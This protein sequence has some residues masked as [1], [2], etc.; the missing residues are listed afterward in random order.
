MQADAG[1][2]RVQVIWQP[3]ADDGGSAVTGYLVTAPEGVEAEVGAGADSALI[4][5]L[6]NGREI[7]LTV[8]AVND[9]GTSAGAD[10]PAVT[11]HRP[12]VA[13]VAGADRYATAADGSDRFGSG[14]ATAFVV[15]GEGFADALAASAAAGAAG[16]P[17]LLTA[18]EH[19]P[20]ATADA[21]RRLAPRKIVVVG[22]EAAVASSVVASL[23]TLAPVS[24]LAGPDR[25][26]TAAAVSRDRFDPGVTAAYLAVGSDFPDALAGGAA[27][28][29]AGGP[30][31][32][33]GRDTVPEATM[34]ELQRLKPDR[35]EL[36]GGPAVVTDGVLDRLRSDTAAKVRRIAGAD[37][38]ETAVAVS[39][40]AFPPARS[41]V[42]VAIGSNFPDA[43]AGGAMAVSDDA[44]VLLVPSS[45]PLPAA[46]RTEL[47]RLRPN[48]IVA[49]GGTAVLPDAVVRE[50]VEAAG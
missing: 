38:Y 25:F 10:S 16:A 45:G 31:L 7:T 32:L 46:V 29:R 39:A 6:T 41:A 14:V 23:R 11:P 47:A 33:V 30:V 8:R 12:D 37:R 43:L 35:I 49:L 5:G 48:R 50:V 9:V 40:T 27:A 34:A 2:G 3:P 15:T 18:R 1:N 19:L 44:P 42:Y 36:L 4:G 13:R 28:A 17:V 24:R 22:G 26:A 20:A 21:L